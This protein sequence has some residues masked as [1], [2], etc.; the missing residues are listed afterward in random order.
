MGGTE[1]FGL[2]VLAALLLLGSC[3]V[4]GDDQAP[5][6]TG[7]LDANEG[8]NALA[9]HE[10]QSIVETEVALSAKETEAPRLDPIP[11]DLLASG[12]R[13]PAADAPRD[14]LSLPEDTPVQIREKLAEVKLELSRR[15]HPI[16]NQRFADGLGEPRSGGM[17]G[18]GYPGYDRDISGI[19][20]IPGKG[21]H[22]VVLPRSEYPELYVFKDAEIRLTQ[23]LREK[24]HEDFLAKRKAQ[25]DML[26]SR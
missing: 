7:P 14:P 17:C 24:E 16:I 21:R 2:G 8:R 23:L 19:R 4:P 5:G 10:G 20:V 9:G 25:S 1:S 6:G 22:V 13:E 26:G 3:G 15:S 18:L 12:T 11:M